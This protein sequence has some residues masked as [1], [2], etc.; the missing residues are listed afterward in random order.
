MVC[1]VVVS[2]HTIRL[3]TSIILMQ[4][5]H[6]HLE[7]V[8]HHYPHSKVVPHHYLINSIIYPTRQAF[9]RVTVPSIHLQR[10]C[11]RSLVTTRPK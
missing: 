5:P 11:Q 10:V 2:L 6:H 4:S 7:A 9:L 8:K 1:Q 3:V